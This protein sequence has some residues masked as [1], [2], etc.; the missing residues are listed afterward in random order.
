MKY[1][2]VFTMSYQIDADDAEQATDMAWDKFR[3]DYGKTF[4]G[5]AACIVEELTCVN[6]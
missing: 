1:N 6:Q 4:A 2:V 3:A 5:N